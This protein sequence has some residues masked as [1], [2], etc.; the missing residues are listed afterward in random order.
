MAKNNK[1]RFFYVLY[2]DKSLTSQTRIADF[3]GDS[4][5]VPPPRASAETSHTF[6]SV[7]EVTII[8]ES[9]VG[10]IGTNRRCVDFSPGS[11]N[12]STSCAFALAQVKLRVLGKGTVSSHLKFKAP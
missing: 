6:H 8:W 9:R 11:V 10:R 1:T 7:S 2:S 4:S 3:L 5:R 12:P